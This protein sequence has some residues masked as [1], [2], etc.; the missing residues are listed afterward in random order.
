MMIQALARRGL[1]LCDIARQVGVHPRTVRKLHRPLLLSKGGENSMTTSGEYCMTAD[2]DHYT[3]LFSSRDVLQVNR[4]TMVDA[5]LISAPSSTKNR[6]KERDPEMHQTK[7]GNQWYLGMKVHI[8]V[9]SQRKLIHSVVATGA[10]V[11]DSQ[12]FPELL[13]GQELRGWGGT[14]Y[15][16][17]RNMIQRPAPDATSFIQAKAHRHWPQSEEEWAK[18]TYWLSIS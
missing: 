13:H 5:T 6:T 10:N 3:D 2:R 15:N 9:D 14:T 7:K 11:H 1:Y 16:G 17:Q 8:G 18:N 4:G 12:V